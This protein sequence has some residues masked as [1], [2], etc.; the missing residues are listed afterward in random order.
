MFPF[1]LKRIDL[2]KGERNRHPDIKIGKTQYLVKYD[3]HYIIG[4]F[5][6]EWYGFTFHFFW[7]ANCLRFGTAD[8]V[9][10][11]HERWQEVWEITKFNDTPEFVERKKPSKKSRYSTLEIS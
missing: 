10:S 9:G 3:G 7:G 11:A 2:S 5:G 1:E 4:S 6:E 8:E